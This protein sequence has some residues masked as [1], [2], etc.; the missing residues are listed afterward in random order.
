MSRYPK[1]SLLVVG[2]YDTIFPR[3]FV[4]EVIGLFRDHN[5]RHQAI[6]FPCGHHSLG[7]FPYAVMDCYQI[8]SFLRKNL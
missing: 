7:E 3:P 6:E 1:T 8:C 2:R 4:R 5:L